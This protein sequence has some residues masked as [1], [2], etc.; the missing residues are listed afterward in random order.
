MVATA[1]AGGTTMTPNHVA[2]IRVTR[3]RRRT[4]VDHK[5]EGR[6]WDPL[7][8]TP[9]CPDPPV[10]CRSGG[11][12]ETT[13]ESAMYFGSIPSHKP[14]TDIITWSSV[15]VPVKTGRSVD[16]L[17]TVHATPPSSS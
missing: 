14:E 3:M 1:A 13:I 5:E 12:A 6:L 4:S 9:D 17:G 10:G 11:R 8:G 7:A 15:R 2:G 16:G